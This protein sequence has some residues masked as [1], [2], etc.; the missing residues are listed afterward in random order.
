ML[1]HQVK[2]TLRLTACGL[3]RMLVAGYDRGEKSSETE[4]RCSSKKCL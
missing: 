1:Y 2:G 4:Y 3:P